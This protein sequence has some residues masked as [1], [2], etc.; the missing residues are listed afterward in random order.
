MS[1]KYEQEQERGVASF[2]PKVTEKAYVRHV[3]LLFFRGS[4]VHFAGIQGTLVMQSHTY[5][6]SS[7]HKH[8]SS[9]QF[10]SL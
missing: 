9:N 1:S 5:K 2:A 7:T 3:Y 10:Q 6:E 4:K 8:R